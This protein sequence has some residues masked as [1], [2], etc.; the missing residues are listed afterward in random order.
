MKRAIIALAALLL[1]GA[2]GSAARAQT[3]AYAANFN[4]YLSNHPGAARWFA[5]NPGTINAP[6]Y[7][8]GYTGTQNYSGAYQ[9]Q[10]MKNLA[11]Y[12]NYLATHPGFAANSGMG[13]VSSYMANYPG[14]YPYPDPTQQLT[15][16]PLTALMAPFMSGYP[17]MQNYPSGY[18][19]TGAS[20]YQSPYAGTSYPPPAQWGDDDEGYHRWH[21]HHHHFDG[22]GYGPYGGGAGP[23]GS[24]GYSGTPISQA[25][26]HRYFAGN[27]GP[28]PAFNGRRFF[29]MS[30]GAG[31]ARWGRNH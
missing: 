1:S 26:N 6:S 25:W 7:P 3:P 24:G 22:D 31:R 16:S 11:T 27:R 5:T 19:G 18:G 8:A 10:Y 21:H 4:R 14:Q 20:F 30:S 15:G 28:G 23:Y 29:G 13:N 9:S 2:I 17:G 12:Q